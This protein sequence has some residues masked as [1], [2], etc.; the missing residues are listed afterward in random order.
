[1]DAREQCMNGGFRIFDTGICLES[2]QY[3]SDL[4]KISVI[5]TTPE[6]LGRTL[7]MGIKL[8]YSLVL[9]S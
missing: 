7:I 9:L 2:L 8:S 5:A 3:N 4:K 6:I 1:V